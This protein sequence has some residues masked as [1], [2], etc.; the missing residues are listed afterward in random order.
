MIPGGLL[1]GYDALSFLS[2]AS[3]DPVTYQILVHMRIILVCFLW[4]LMFKHKLS[5]T[6]WLAILLFAAAGV[7]KGID[8][9]RMSEV[10]LY[11]GIQIV[12]IQTLMSAL[13]NV[14]SEV[15]LKEM[16]MPADLVNTTMY[17][18][19]LIWLV[20]ALLYK[21]GSGALYSELLS[22]AAWARLQGDSYMVGSICSL[23]AFG[24][25]TA[26]LLKMLSNIVK[27][28]S[29][30][31]VIVATCVVQVVNTTMGIL[32]CLMAILGIGVYAA[33]PLQHRDAEAELHTYMSPRGVPMKSPR[34][35]H[36]PSADFQIIDEDTNI[37][38]D[39]LED[40]P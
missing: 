13:A 30:G 16:P 11:R 36:G 7:T 39:K 31:V 4:Q 18:W 29:G 12:V 17:L 28:L 21:Q 24:I 14:S 5:G 2:L 15:L 26:Y 8:R 27:E 34:V 20:I 9:S 6:Q 22:S 19:G 35:N 3:L 37:G 10:E 32:G 33:D 38:A 23:I 40:D 25:I 1:A